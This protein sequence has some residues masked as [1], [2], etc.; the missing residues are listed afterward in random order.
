MKQVSKIIKIEKCF[1]YSRYVNIL[2]ITF[3]GSKYESFMYQNLGT[4]LV[5]RAK[6]CCYNLDFW[7]DWKW[8]KSSVT[9]FYE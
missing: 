1:G 8:E 4:I 2:G 3:E 5:F 7:Y 6:H 9:K